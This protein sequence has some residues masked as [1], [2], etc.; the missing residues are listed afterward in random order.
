MSS[1]K[2]VFYALGHA[3]VDLEFRVSEQTLKR[4]RFEKGSHQLLNLA[5]REQ[6]LAAL[7]AEYPHEIYCGGSASNSAAICAHLGLPSFFQGKV[8]VDEHGTS[9]LQQL[10]NDHVSHRPEFMR[11]FSLPTGCSIV[12]ITPDGERTMCTHLGAATSL[13][14]QDIDIN[15]L[16]SSEYLYLE[17]YGLETAENFQTL[18]YV[19]ELAKK[20]GTKLAFSLSA[21]SVVEQY[22][23]NLTAFLQGEKLDLLFCNVWEALA[24]SHTQRLEDAIPRLTQTAKCFVVTQGAKGALVFDGTEFIQIP[25]HDV[26][27]VDLL[28]A[29]DVFAGAFMF[30][31]T[32]TQNYKLS[33]DFAS[34]AAAQV[35]KQ[36]GPRLPSTSL[37]KLANHLE[38]LL[39]AQKFSK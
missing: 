22:H 16:C 13:L 14:I 20:F 1:R 5:K 36:A 23:Q 3:L 27:V 33:G 31:I 35:V 11:D 18:T 9:Y 37:K 26:K 24:F 29:G 7:S 12:L 4:L 2:F 6:L 25:A 17:A 21:T 30:A 10:R 38:N 28:G 34:D 19:K 39:R 8:G 15:A 32:K